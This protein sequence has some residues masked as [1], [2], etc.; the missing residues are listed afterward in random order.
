VKYLLQIGNDDG[1]WHPVE[2]IRGVL[3]PK[4]IFQLWMNLLVEKEF[5]SSRKNNDRTEYNNR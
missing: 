5:Y 1:T 3:I 2:D 4:M